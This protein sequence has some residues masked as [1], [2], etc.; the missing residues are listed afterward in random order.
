MHVGVVL[1]LISVPELDEDSG[2]LTASF[3]RSSVVLRRG[4]RPTRLWHAAGQR[5]S[6]DR[7]DW[8]VHVAGGSLPPDILTAL[9]AQLP[10]R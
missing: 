10:D 5:W 8:A 4:P 1:D 6:T 2:A 7:W 9:Q 3:G